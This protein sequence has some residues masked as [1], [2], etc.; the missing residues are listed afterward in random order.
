M[1]LPGCSTWQEVTFPLVDLHLLVSRP[2]WTFYVLNEDPGVFLV[3]PVC[4]R[5]IAL[6]TSCAVRPL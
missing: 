2:V 1:V 6:E 3:R 5:A 4:H